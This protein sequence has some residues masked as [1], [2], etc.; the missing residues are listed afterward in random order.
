[1]PSEATF[2]LAGLLFIAAAL[3][4]VYARYLEEREDR[5]P[6]SGNALNADYIKG[7][8]FLLN[9]QPDQALEV[10]IRMVE[11]DNDT[12]ETHFALGGLFRRRGEVERAIRVHQNLIARPNLTQEQRDQAFFALAEDYMRSGLYD[13]AEA[14]FTKFDEQSKHRSAALRKLVRIYEMTHDWEQAIAAY[15]KLVASGGAG[16]G[17]DHVAHYYCEMAEQAALSGEN[18][19]AD[20]MLSKALERTP[21]SVRA[22]LMRAD[23]LQAAGNCAAAID[24]YTA[25]MHESPQLISHIIPKLAKSCRD[26]DRSDD[27]GE[28]LAALIEGDESARN[29][30]AIA[31]VRDESIQNPVAIRCLQDYASSHP[32]LAAL[33]DMEHLHSNDAGVAAAT[34]ERIRKALQKIAATSARYRCSECGYTTM[35][36]LWQCPSCREWETVVPHR[37][38][39]LG[40]VLG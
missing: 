34:L 23:A 14:I 2:L 28:I 32:I 4:Y 1:M 6:G 18:T 27:M 30:I 24:L 29:A 31:A 13:R 40:A 9:E 35:E 39:A 22:R 33:I 19:Y 20:E 25:L 36:R 12:L 26:A 21:D 15:E 11:V 16:E 8:N 38:L 17:P 3:G 7:L 5:D 37:E 10:F